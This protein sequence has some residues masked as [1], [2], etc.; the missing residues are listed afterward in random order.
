MNC[1]IKKEIE[2]FITDYNLKIN[3]H[4][5][6]F[7]NADSVINELS[8]LINDSIKFNTKPWPFCN[9]VKVIKTPKDFLEVAYLRSLVYKKEGYLKEFPE[10]II[11]LEYQKNDSYSQI[12]YRKMNGFIT[13]SVKVIFG[14]YGKLPSETKLNYDK[15][16]K[17]YKNIFEWS[18]FV[19]HPN[20]KQKLTEM[21]SN[22]QAAYYFYTFYNQSLYILTLSKKHFKRYQSY[23]GITIIK[24]LPEGY[25][26]IEVPFTIVSWD[27]SKVSRFFLEKIIGTNLVKKTE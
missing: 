21:K 24:E 20:V 4:H 19:V 3:T 2:K 18:R 27:M 15:F 26:D 11:G 7:K 17:L 14:T 8:D 22:F 9:L 25:G 1:E 23:G 10:K 5:P 13:S 16:R 6:G 12:F